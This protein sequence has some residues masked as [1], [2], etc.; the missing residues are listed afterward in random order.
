VAWRRLRNLP[1][2]ATDVRPYLAAFALAFP[3]AAC[4]G[5]SPSA[6]DVPRDGGSARPEGDTGAGV[7]AREAGSAPTD[8]GG[9][10]VYVRILAIQTPIAGESAPAETPVD[11]RAGLSGLTLLK[12]A[13]D[14]SP[15]VLLDSPSPIVT[16]YNAGSTTLLGTVPASSLVAGTYTIAR[17]PVAYVN[18]TVAGTYHYEGMAIPGDFTDLIALSAG[19]SLDGAVRDRGWWSSSFSVA[20]MTEGSVTGENAEIAQPG[21]ASGI[22]LDLSGSVAAYVFPIN[23]TVPASIEESSEILF[24][25]NTYEDFHWTDQTMAGYTTGVFDVSPGS[26]EPVTQLG[27]NSFTVTLGPAE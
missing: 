2:F 12:D 8:A 19:V 22:A 21:A 4:S 25:V 23:L 26:F 13:N 9:P 20:G 17:I 27:G 1:R 10:V 15:L 5:T 14:P 6:L 24:T 11:Q 3:L 18:F 7:D 16:P